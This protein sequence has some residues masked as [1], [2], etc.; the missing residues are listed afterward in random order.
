MLVYEYVCFC[1]M[2]EDKCICVCL[3]PALISSDYVHGAFCP[4]VLVAS[5]SPVVGRGRDNMVSE[6]HG[7]NN[8]PL[9][10][11]KVQ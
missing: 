2:I 11:K 6:C 7:C 9:W 8:G 1:Y 10:A 5:S 4:V 3:I